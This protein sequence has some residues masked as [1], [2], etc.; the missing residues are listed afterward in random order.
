MYSFEQRKLVV[1][2]LL[3]RVALGLEPRPEDKPGEPTRFIRPIEVDACCPKPEV[4]EPSR[5]EVRNAAVRDSNDQ[6]HAAGR[7]FL[8]AVI[9]DDDFKPRTSFFA[10][11]KR[12]RGTSVTRDERQ[13]VHRDE[14]L[15]AIDYPWDTVK[16]LMLGGP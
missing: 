4:G 11:I 2:R 15:A 9:V 16:R 1:I 5:S 12:L 6:D 10:E 13:A 3:E 7:P 8:S 14:Y